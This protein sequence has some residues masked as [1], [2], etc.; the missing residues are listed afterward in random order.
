MTTTALDRVDAAPARAGVAL[1]PG[2]TAG[3]IIGVAADAAAQFSDVVKKQ[4]MFKRIGDN[5]HILIEAWQTIGA[6]TGVLADKGI[7]TEL[8]WPALEP[9][10]DDEPPY[11]EGREPRDHTTPAW[12]AWNDADKTRRGWELHRDLLHARAVGRAFGFTAAFRAAKGGVDVGWGEGRC[13]R[14]EASKVNQEDYALSSMAQTRG[15]S[16]ALGA[17]LK[18]VV[19]LAGYETTP[20]EELDGA[21]STSTAPAE[22]ATAPPAAPWGPVA[23]DPQ[24]EA[25]AASVRTIAG[26]PIEAESF[27]LA[28]G[29][30]F[31]GVPEACVTMLRGLARYVGAA[32][33]KAGVVPTENAPPDPAA[34]AYHNPPTEPEATP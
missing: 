12:R 16:R 4:R 20:A 19:K 11:P 1:F 2:A 14:G 24:M 5:D 6:L 27:I 28:M 15:Q 3:E 34:S 26:V 22:G 13:T 7:V 25:A 10:A 29:Q 30:H 17:P 18:F 8:P 31:D 33:A 32:R 23:D 9:L 21:T